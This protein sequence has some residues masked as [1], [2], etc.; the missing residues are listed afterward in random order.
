MFNNDFMAIKFN[1]KCW[2]F[3]T[4]AKTGRLLTNTYRVIYCIWLI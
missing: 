4:S 2:D 3:L 1:F